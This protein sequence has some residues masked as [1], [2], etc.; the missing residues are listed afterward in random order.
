MEKSAKYRRKA[1]CKSD[2]ELIFRIYKELC[3][4]KKKEKERKS[5][6]KKNGQWT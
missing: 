1:I 6:I 2:V 4:Q 3:K 5:K